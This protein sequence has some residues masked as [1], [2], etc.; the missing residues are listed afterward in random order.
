[1]VSLNQNHHQLQNKYKHE[2]GK[3][4]EEIRK[5]KNEIININNNNN[6]KKNL[7]YFKN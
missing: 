2:V 7:I 3:K 6:L 4:N 1:M 5:L